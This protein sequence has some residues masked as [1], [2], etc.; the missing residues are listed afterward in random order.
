MPRPTPRNP[1]QPVPFSPRHPH[2]PHPSPPPPVR[3]LPDLGVGL[4]D[5][6][7][8]MKHFIAKI[9][10]DHDLYNTPTSTLTITLEK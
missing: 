5:A 8:D 3:S 1:I 4:D 2:I 9:E 7:L 10:G 6:A